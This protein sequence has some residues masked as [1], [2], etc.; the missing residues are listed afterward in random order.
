MDGEEEFK[1]LGTIFLEAIRS[2]LKLGIACYHLVQDLLSS[3]LLAKNIQIKL[4]RTI[5]KIRM[6]DIVTV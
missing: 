5:L 3:S 4:Y 2:R 6:Q 1:Y